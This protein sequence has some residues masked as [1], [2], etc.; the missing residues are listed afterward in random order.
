MS[1]KS[2]LS[3]K[4]EDVKIEPDA[5]ERF[6][7]AADVVIKSGPKHRQGPPIKPTERPP[8]K[9]RVHKGRTKA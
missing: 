9:G 3:G 4:A 7:R 1:V 5:W 6:E 2:K 8:S